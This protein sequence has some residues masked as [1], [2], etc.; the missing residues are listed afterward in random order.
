MLDYISTERFVFEI[1]TNEISRELFF[2]NQ[3]KSLQLFEI[4]AA[5]FK[6]MSY[7]Q[8]KIHSNGLRKKL[9]NQVMKAYFDMEKHYP[10]IIGGSFNE[11]YL[12]NKLS[13]EEP[14]FKYCAKFGRFY[15]ERNA[16]AKE[17]F[18]LNEI[19]LFACKKLEM[20][21]LDFPKFSSTIPEDWLDH[22]PV[23]PNYTEVHGFEYDI[24][25]SVEKIRMSET[26]ARKKT[27]YLFSAQ[28]GI[29]VVKK[30]NLELS[31]FICQDFSNK[32]FRDFFES[33][34]DRKKSVSH[35]GNTNDLESSVYDLL[36]N[37][38][39]LMRK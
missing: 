28:D 37:R 34:R 38:F 39:L 27:H 30:I 31:D 33:F 26:P 6:N 29:V 17:L 4:H 1:Y 5:W 21:C 10:D 11:Y 13:I 19:I 14:F 8:C 15:N 9:M 7:Q 3:D 35:S 36:R 24:Y 25:D 18:F 23:I 20:K 2:L 22:S 16:D 32:T 12:T